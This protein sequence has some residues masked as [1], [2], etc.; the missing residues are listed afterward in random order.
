M[1]AGG[2]SPNGF[3]GLPPFTGV[4][5]ELGGPITTA[6]LRSAVSI[7]IESMSAK[8]TSPWLS[9][10]SGSWNE[11]FFSLKAVAIRRLDLPSRWKTIEV[12]GDSATEAMLI[13]FPLSST[14]TSRAR[15]N[16][17]EGRLV[18]EDFSLTSAANIGDRR[19]AKQSRINGS[20]LIEI[21]GK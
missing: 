10:V 17:V 3:R 13:S 19:D 5:F 4:E 18:S 6:L 21:L 8:G 1:G 9:S 15:M 11:P 14:G 7:P 2:R 12:P 20:I 16:C